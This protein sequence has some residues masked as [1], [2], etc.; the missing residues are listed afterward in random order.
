MSRVLV[1]LALIGLVWWVVRRG[2]AAPPAAAPQA[3]L[4]EPL[5]RCAHCGAHFPAADAVRGADAA[6]VY[7]G[8]AHHALAQ[9]RQA[10][11]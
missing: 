2:R 8:E 6:V 9:R 10:A 7:C 4:P 5:L 3:R 11:R 1:W